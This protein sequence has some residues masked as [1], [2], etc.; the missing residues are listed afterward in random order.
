M[1]KLYTLK[2]NTLGVQAASLRY[3]NKSVSNLS[4]SDAVLVFTGGGFHIEAVGGDMNEIDFFCSIIPDLLNRKRVVLA[5]GQRQ[6]EGTAGIGQHQLRED[7]PGGVS[8]PDVDFI[9]VS[10]SGFDRLGV[11]GHTGNRDLDLDRP[12]GRSHRLRTREQGEH[13]RPDEKEQ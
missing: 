10:P 5:F 1:T 7:G 2:Q 9:P 12:V 8:E 6:P 4:L 11:R 13:R 3:F